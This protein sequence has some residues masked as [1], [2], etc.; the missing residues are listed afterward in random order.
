MISTEHPKVGRQIRGTHP[1][2]FRSGTWA[3]VRAVVEARGRACYLVEFTDAVTDLWPV[4]DPADR[5]EFR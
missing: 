2:A 5:Y 4:D 1:Y 3:T